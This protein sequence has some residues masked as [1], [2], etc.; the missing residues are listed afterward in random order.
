MSL[1]LRPSIPGLSPDVSP[2]LRRVVPWLVMA[3]LY[4]AEIPAHAQTFNAPQS[5]LETAPAHPIDAE[6]ARGATLLENGDLQADEVLRAA[7][8]A[9]LKEL[10]AA[11][12]GTRLLTAPPEQIPEFGPLALMTRR[13]AQAHLW[14]GKAADQ[15]AQRDIALIA[16]ARAYRFAGPNRFDTNRLSREIAFRISAL[17]RDGLPSIAPDDTLDTLST[18]GLWKPRR[19]RFNYT[20]VAF[21][22]S[23]PHRPGTVPLPSVQELLITQGKAFPPES[24]MT[25]QSRRDKA[26]VAPLYRTIADERLPSVLKLGYMTAG[27]VRETI[28][29]NRGQWKQVVRVYYPHPI[30]TKDN[31]D[32]RLRAEALCEQF[33]K[34]HTLMRNGSGLNNPYSNDGVTTLWLSEVSALWPADDDDPEVQAQLGV[35]MPKPNTLAAGQTRVRT[36]V[37]WSPVSMPWLAA[38]QVMSAPGD[39]MFFKVGTPRSE[40]EWLRQIV[41]EYG[42]VVLPPFGGFQPPAEPFGNGAVGETVA[43]LWAAAAGDE[44]NVTVPASTP[45][46]LPVT[47]LV[48]NPSRPKPQNVP[49][50][51]TLP[52]RPLREELLLHVARHAV[53]ALRFFNAHGPNSAWRNDRDNNGLLYLQGLH[54]YLDRVYGTPLLGAAS[55]PLQQR[56]AAHFAVNKSMLPTNTTALLNN[57][58]VALR[59]PFG[60]TSKYLPIW[61]PGAIE[62]LPANLPPTQIIN[63]APLLLRRGERM[64]TKLYIPPTAKALHIEWKGAAG[65]MLRPIGGGK[66]TLRPPSGAGATGAIDIGNRAAWQRLAFAATSD[67]TIMHSGFVRK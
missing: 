45:R 47:S 31:R 36:E 26:V 42:H 52:A 46:A 20:N 9:A 57:V 51:A 15:F 29:P 64:A 65:A 24:A 14:W 22:P 7:A 3:S 28:G 67:V 34:L 62:N 63:R 1:M 43:M 13:A 23:L 58:P 61:L 44:W 30:L 37:D 21:R 2:S 54:V 11:P 53:P 56:S 27:F 41:H 50:P 4:A 10:A 55:L 35:R 25:A 19:I 39:I 12:G 60:A 18:L 6:I 40:G 48:D 49:E 66:S 32:D 5:T 38:G 16:L 33:L 8:Q 17:L 59:N